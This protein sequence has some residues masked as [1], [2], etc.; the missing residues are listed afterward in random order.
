MK[1]LLRLGAPA[2]VAG[3]LLVAGSAPG[4]ATVM[5]A[6]EAGAA[7]QTCYAPAYGVT[8]SC[9]AIA[10]HSAWQPNDPAFDGTPTDAVWI[11][12]DKTGVSPDNGVVVAQNT[13]PNHPQLVYTLRFR[14]VAG[15][16][17]SL[18]VWADDTALI[19]VDGHK[20][21]AA[22]LD[23]NFA[24]N[25]TCQDGTA[26]CA[27][28]RAFIDTVTLDDTLDHTL[29]IDAYQIGNGTTHDSNPFGILFAAQLSDDPPPAVPEPGTLAL[30][31]AAL[32]GLAVARRRR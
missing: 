13:D 14:A 1:H 18:E 2:L 32:A 25:H 24:D 28:G 20:L 11:S 17:I 10:P 26:S 31:G 19:S 23:T 22:T 15:S 9:V 8:N 6:S 7:N 27:P 3:A 12:F 5:L 30:F 16:Q 21:N 29:E 4:S